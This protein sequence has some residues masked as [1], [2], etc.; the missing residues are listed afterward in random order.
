MVLYITTPP[1]TPMWSDPRTK[2]SKGEQKGL[3][4]ALWLGFGEGRSLWKGEGKVK[5]PDHHKK[6]KTVRK[7]L[8]GR[9]CKDQNMNYMWRVLGFLLCFVV[10]KL[11]S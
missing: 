5:P 1:P 4:P 7:P 6:T 8:A 11:H 10:F 2:E 3:D 9:S